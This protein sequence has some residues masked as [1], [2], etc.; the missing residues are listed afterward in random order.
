MLDFNVPCWVCCRFQKKRHKNPQSNPVVSPCAKMLQD[1]SEF[2]LSQI[3]RHLKKRVQWAT[4]THP[5]WRSPTKMALR[6][7]F[8]KNTR[9]WYPSR[10]HPAKPIFHYL[11]S[12]Q[13]H[14][15]LKYLYF[16]RTYASSGD[17]TGHFFQ[18]TPTCYFGG[19]QPVLP[20]KPGRSETEICSLRGWQ[21]LWK[22][23]QNNWPADDLH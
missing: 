7:T 2:L 23:I 10:I 15:G 21:E 19:W 18:W 11:S 12:Y 9:G 20:A 13:R 8:K 22:R 5:S 17:R 14:R 3:T 1:W 16:S 6:M 4:E